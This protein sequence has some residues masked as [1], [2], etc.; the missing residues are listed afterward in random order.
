MSSPR[1]VIPGQFYMITR[2]CTQRQFLLRPDPA[3]NN[4]FTYCLIEAAQRCQIE[5]LLPC[6]LSNHYHAVIFDRWGRYP[7]FAEHF[8]KMFARCQ[9]AL[10]GRWENFWSSEQVCVV[11]LVGREDVMDKLVY[12]ATN[13]VKDGLVDRVDHWPGVNGLHALLTG[14]G[15]RAKRPWH[16]FRPEGI[17]PGAV[18]LRLT[19]PAELG[20]AD[21][22]LEE[23]RQRVEAAVA[24]IGAERQRA[25]TRVYGRRAVLQQRWWDRPRSTEPRRNLRPRIAA[26]SKWARIEALLRNRA[27]LVAYAAARAAWQDGLSVVFPVGTYWLR[28]YANVPTAAG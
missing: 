22:V 14:R 5:V 6:A 28:R 9:N 21:E 7:E 8:H 23:L 16:F 4:A 2:R 20:P 27:F 15:L 1:Q 26:R 25:G 18:E 11:K 24:A 10:R 19:I 13:P 17:M 3:T 12:T